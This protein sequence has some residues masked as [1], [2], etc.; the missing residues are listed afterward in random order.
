LSHAE[1]I[2]KQFIKPP[3][4]MFNN[5][6]PKKP[7][8]AFDG[9]NFSDWEKAIDCTLVNAFD[10]DGSFIK[11]LNNFDKLNRPKNQ[12]VASLIRNSLDPALLTIVESGTNDKPR[13]LFVLLREKCKRSG[14]RHKLMAIEKLLRL[15]SKQPPA[16]ESWLA[17]WC[18]L[19]ANL[20]RANPTLDEVWGFSFKPL[21]H[22]HMASTRRILSIQLVNLLTT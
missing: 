6:N 12:A 1:N 2:L 15:A 17:S 5:E 16:S 19:K 8:L 10:R 20:N 18:T 3:N 14:R 7:N 4:N 9:S 11:N 22:H 21:P 13:E